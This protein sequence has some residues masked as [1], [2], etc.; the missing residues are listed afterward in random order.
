MRTE[1]G[2]GVPDSATFAQALAE[3]K[4]EGSNLL[5]VG[6]ATADA[7]AAASRRLL[8]DPGESRRRL[9]VFTRGADVCAGLPEDTDPSSVRVI[10][11]RTTDGSAKPTDWP[12]GLDEIVVEA[13]M[14]SPLAMEV[15]E[16]IEEFDEETDGLEPA[17]L[18]LC[19]DSITSLYRQHQSENV[20]RLLHLVTSRVR[21]VKGMGHFHLRLDKDS[22]YVRLLEP[23]FDA[24][25]EMRVEGDAAQ[26]RWHLRDQEV[27]SDWVDL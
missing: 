24:V 6:E 22:E 26:Q 19:F 14:L 1:H 15:I 20:F 2:G 10:S 9:F 16:A 21:Q 5:L 17:Q 12:D 25:I 4:R 18:R 23:M 8:G 7:H 3:L 13:D 11:Q 27:T